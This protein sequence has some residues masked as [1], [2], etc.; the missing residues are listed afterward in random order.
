[1]RRAG[2]WSD[3]SDENHDLD[4]IGGFG[5]LLESIANNDDWQYFV[6]VLSKI[7]TL[8]CGHCNKTKALLAKD[9]FKSVSILI[10]DI[11]KLDE[12]SG[13]VMQKALADMTGQ[14]SVP[15]IFIDGKQIGG[16]SDIQALYAAG[17]LNLA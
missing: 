2:K 7:P 16:N 5:S 15:N 13:P 12:P 6:F 8:R 11:D 1:M 10:R 4:T 3:S 14:T 9:E 17:N